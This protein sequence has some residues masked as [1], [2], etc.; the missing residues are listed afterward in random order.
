MFSDVSDTKNTESIFTIDM[1]R[2]K[3]AIYVS[4]TGKKFEEGLFWSSS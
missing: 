2:V 3:F 1:N 4:L